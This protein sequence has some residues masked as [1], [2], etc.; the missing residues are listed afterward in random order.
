M[1]CKFFSITSIIWWSLVDLNAKL[2]D[3]KKDFFCSES[4]CLILKSEQMKKGKNMRLGAWLLVFLML[5]GFCTHE[6]VADGAKVQVK[7]DIASGNYSVAAFLPPTLK[8]SQAFPGLALLDGLTI[9]NPELIY[10]KYEYVDQDLKVTIKPGLNFA[11]TLEFVGP[12][13][14][15][16]QLTKLKEITVAGVLP[17]TA[18]GAQLSVKLPGDLSFG[19]LGKATD[20]SLELA[21]Q[22]TGPQFGIGVG[23]LD[24]NIP[25][26]DI[27]ALAAKLL[28]GA[29]AGTID[30]QVKEPIK[31]PFGIPG[32][33]IQNVALQDTSF[34]YAVPPVITRFGFAGSMNIGSKTM[35]VAIKSSLPDKFGIFGQINELCLADL[36][37]FLGK[38]IGQTITVQGLP[39]LCLRNAKVLL[40]SQPFAVDNLSFPQGTQISGDITLLGVDGTMHFMADKTKGA[41]GSGDLS[42]IILDPLRITGNGPKGGPMIALTLGQKPDIKLSGK[43]QLDPILNTQTDLTIQGNSI[44]FNTSNKFKIATGA[45]INLTVI[46]ISPDIKKLDFMLDISFDNSLFTYLSKQVD[47]GL[48][49]AGKEL[50]GALKTAAEKVQEGQK[51]VQVLDAQIEKLKKEIDALYD[52]SLLKQGTKLIEAGAKEVGKAA[53]AVG[54]E[55][56]HLDDRIKHADQTIA[57][58]GSD[59]KALGK[60]IEKLWNEIEKLGKEIG[61]GI[62]DIV[63]GKDPV[64]EEKKRK[65][66]EKVA[67]EAAKAIKEL[68]QLAEIAHQKALQK[69]KEA[70]Q[71]QQQALTNVQKKLDDIKNAGGALSAVATQL[72]QKLQANK[73]ADVRSQLGDINKKLAENNEQ[74]SKLTMD[75]FFA[76]GKAAW[77]NKNGEE[78]RKLKSIIINLASQRDSINLLLYPAENELCQIVKDLTPELDRILSEDV[79]VQTVLK[80]LN[81]V[82]AQGKQLTPRAQELVK[83]LPDIMKQRDD[84][85]AQIRTLNDTIDSK[86]QQLLDIQYVELLQKLKEWGFGNQGA[87][88]VGSWLETLLERIEKNPKFECDEKKQNIVSDIHGGVRAILAYKLHPNPSTANVLVNIWHFIDTKQTGLRGELE[89]GGRPTK[90]FCDL[91]TGTITSAVS[92]MQNSIHQLNPWGTLGG[93]NPYNDRLFG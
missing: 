54:N 41:S 64:K 45:E 18:V 31:N 17:K 26:L 53:V 82:I 6:S 44:S 21:F 62:K 22:Q 67:N 56:L 88:Y 34:T 7:G 10:S 55:I 73:A 46:G 32:I 70:T 68:D 92:W 77:D 43:L 28:I 65:E 80:K 2:D 38:I 30:A 91:S 36:F 72:L 63:S 19:S 23:N 58:L 3:G 48:R 42:P 51:A 76:S 16:E 79:P 27:P 40:A 85:R 81:A 11:G 14:P 50:T 13:A 86:E 60:N 1:L 47:D 37:D 29:A 33:T 39:P 12:L 52:K 9:T 84:L 4:I 69:N 89:M 35:T 93:R 71:A 24:L 15:V 61:Q 5:G 75:R 87:V 74:L 66:E 78:L 59:I 8:L 90:D 25:G 57:S 83:N 49:T 20:L